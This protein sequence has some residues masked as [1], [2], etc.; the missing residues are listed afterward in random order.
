MAYLELINCWFFHWVGRF[1]VRHGR[2]TISF[3]TIF[4]AQYSGYGFSLGKGSS[5]TFAFISVLR[6]WAL[7]SLYQQGDN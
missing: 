6:I 1:S 5:R 3:S 2:D 4:V 7:E